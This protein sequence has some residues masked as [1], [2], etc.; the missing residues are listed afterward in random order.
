MTYF[1]ELA[2][3]AKDFIM[4][5]GIE[6]LKAQVDTQ[7]LKNGNIVYMYFARFDAGMVDIQEPALY[8]A[9]GHERTVG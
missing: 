6:A 8:G 5:G 4:R 3:A 2:P 9:I 1:W 7:T